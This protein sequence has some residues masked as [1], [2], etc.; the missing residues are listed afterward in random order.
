MSSLSQTQA[1]RLH[2]IGRASLA[3]AVLVVLLGCGY[4][5]KGMGLGAPPGVGTIA[6]T[7]LENKT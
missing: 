4:H 7:V 2:D 3:L 5:L 6:V 1:V